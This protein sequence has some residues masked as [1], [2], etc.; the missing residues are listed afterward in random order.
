MNIN[1]LESIVCHLPIEYR[2]VCRKW[3]KMIPYNVNKLRQ[4]LN[5][6]DT[7]DILKEEFKDTDISIIINTIFEDNRISD[8]VRM[9]DKCKFE[10]NEKN[11]SKCTSCE[12]LICIDCIYEYCK[13]CNNGVCEKKKCVKNY[14]KDYFGRC[15]CYDF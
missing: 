10:E 5:K 1:I 4:I 6:K 8:P 3:S 14:N 11:I 9:C 15:T 13:T 7:F 2:L 12:K